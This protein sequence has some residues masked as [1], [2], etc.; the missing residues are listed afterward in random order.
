MS[1]AHVSSG[2][3]YGAKVSTGGAARANQSS[4]IVVRD[5]G[6]PYTGPTTVAPS[7]TEQTL[8]TE[9]KFLLSDIT[10]EAIPDDYVGSA[11]PRNDSSDLTAS[12]DTVT[13]PAGYYAANASKSVDAAAW[14]AGSI[15]QPTMTTTVDAAGLVTAKASGTMSVWPIQTSGWAQSSRAYPIIF[16]ETDTLQLP[17]QDADTITPSSSSQTAVAAGRFTTGAVT[18]AAIQTETA[19][20]TP[21]TSA[22]TIYPSSDH[23]IDEVDVAAIQTETASVTPST[24]AQTITPTAGH[25]FDEVDVAAM[26]SGSK[27]GSGTRTITVSTESTKKNY[28]IA[29]PDATSGYYPDTTFKP[30]ETLSLTRQSAT[31]TPSNTTQTVSPSGAFYYLESV[32]VDPMPSGTEGTPIATKG[33]VNNHSIDVTPSV[34]NTAGYISG[35]TK[36]GTAVSVSASELVSGTKTISANGTGIDVANYAAVDV[37]VPQGGGGIV[38]TDTLDSHGGI[39]REITAVD[40]SNDTVDAAHLLSGYTAHDST[41]TAIT[42]TASAAQ[43]LVKYAIRPDATLVQSWSY[44]KWLHADEEITIPGYSTSAQTI[45]ASAALGSV[46]LDRDNYYYYVVER[47]LTIPTYSVTTHNKGRCEYHIGAHIFEVIDIPGSS[48]HSLIEPTRYYTSRLNTVTTV[49]A[50]YREIYYSASSTLSTYST[51]AY[52]ICQAATAPSISSGTLTINSPTVTSRGSTS[53]FVNTYA[54]AVTDIR[55]Q[56]VIELYK[57]PKGTALDGWG[58]DQLM[59]QIITCLNSGTQKLT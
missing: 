23:Y 50:S 16:N 47:M 12:G 25:F 45:K 53:Y 46:A 57:S 54:N 34:T 7:D 36:T 13:A 28:A 43:P 29:W 35:G 9:E 32:T 17:T 18:V 52:G 59:K 31:V 40:L 6:E 20:V 33:A 41:G 42:G 27:G 30:S 4:P 2:S 14:K 5:F 38:V 22:Q 48:M 55:A 58:N 21:S 49:L 39:I 1:N 15:L 8:A 51:Q 37:D 19:S 10:V 44:D 24:S 3:G 56:Y 26:P 11:V